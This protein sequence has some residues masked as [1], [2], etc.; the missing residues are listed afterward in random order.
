[1][2]ARVVLPRCDEESN[3]CQ[4]CL[5]DKSKADSLGGISARLRHKPT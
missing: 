2:F 5:I 4:E 1:M 3:L